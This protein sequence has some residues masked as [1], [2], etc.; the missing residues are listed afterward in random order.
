MPLASRTRQSLGVD[1]RQ[2]VYVQLGALLAGDLGEI[3]EVS[4]G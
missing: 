2:R 1:A 3:E 4:L